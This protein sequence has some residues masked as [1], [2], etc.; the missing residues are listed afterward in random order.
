MVKLKASSLSEDPYRSVI[1]EYLN[2][3]LGWSHEKSQ[4]FWDVNLIIKLNIAFPN[5]LSKEEIE[6]NVDIKC[7][8]NMYELIKVTLHI[9]K[10]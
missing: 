5:G 6:K 3:V 9:N 8:M 7:Q 10:T 2:R 4:K 1:I